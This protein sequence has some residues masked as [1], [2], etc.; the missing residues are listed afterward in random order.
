MHQTGVLKR[1]LADRWNMRVPQRLMGANPPA[2]S[3]RPSD[4]ILLLSGNGTHR[5]LTACVT[6]SASRKGFLSGYPSCSLSLV[7]RARCL[8]A[9][10]LHPDFCVEMPAR[11]PPSVTGSDPNQVASRRMFRAIQWTT[12]LPEDESRILIIEHARHFRFPSVPGF[13]RGSARKRISPLGSRR[14][15]LA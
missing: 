5:S 7:F 9:G 12:P 3:C 6:R 1:G 11:Y 10:R 4:P 14:D 13:V 2:Y 15:D 8:W